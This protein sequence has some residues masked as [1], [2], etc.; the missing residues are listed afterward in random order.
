M[1]I[2]FDKL[3]QPTY[4]SSHYLTTTS[5]HSSLLTKLSYN[6]Q[7][8]FIKQNAETTFSSI[9]RIHK[10]EKNCGGYHSDE[11]CSQLLQFTLYFTTSYNR[12]SLHKN[13]ILFS[14]LSMRDRQREKCKRQKN[15]QPKL[16][17]SLPKWK[18]RL[19]RYLKIWVDQF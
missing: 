9:Q 5:F 7:W 3:F 10:K 2:K 17:I 13:I 15:S 19:M 18:K 12:P 6:F 11:N 14:C 8:I 16:R 4:Y 1:N